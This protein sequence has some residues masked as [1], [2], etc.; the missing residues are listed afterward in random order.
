MSYKKE[1]NHWFILLAVIIIILVVVALSSSNYSEIAEREAEEKRRKEIE[2]KLRQEL[3]DLE[4]KLEI[5]EKH[6]SIHAFTEGYMNELCE[7]RYRQLLQILI[8]LL[9][10]VNVLLI[11]LVPSMKILDVFSWNA[12]AL[13]LFNLL[14]IFFFTSVKRG[15]EYLKGIALNYI[16]FRVYE[17]RDKNYFTKKVQ[18]YEREIERLRMEIEAKKKSIDTHKNE[19]SN[20]VD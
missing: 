1:E 2:E 4:N 19:S 10:V 3:D 20:S 18:F 12:G 17:N 8:V 11:W 13:V 14:A 6:K 9:V 16:E 5:Y 7:K 15:K